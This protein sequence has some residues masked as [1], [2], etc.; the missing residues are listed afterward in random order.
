M[1]RY[2][3]IS[4]TY[5][6]RRFLETSIRC[7]AFNNH[8]VI[9]IR[10]CTI[11]WLPL[12]HMAC[13]YEKTGHHI[14]KSVWMPVIGEELHIKLEEDNEYAVAVILDGCTVC[15]LPLT[16]SRMLWLSCSCVSR[17]LFHYLHGMKLCSKSERLVLRRHRIRVATPS[18]WPHGYPA[19][20]EDSA[21]I[22]VNYM[23]TQR[24]LEARHLLE[25]GVHESSNWI[26]HECC[27]TTVTSCSCFEDIHVHYL[28]DS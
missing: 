2:L 19:C 5:Y 24:V 1:P 10:P 26:L 14:Y 12:V 13:R 27:I 20:I 11:F 3:F 17:D 18:S 4:G 23:D 8:P 7:P 16:I 9:I 25:A 6:T 28:E 15:Y 22:N 21:F